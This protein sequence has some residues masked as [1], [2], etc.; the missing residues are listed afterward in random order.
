MLVCVATAI[1]SRAAQ[2]WID[3]ELVSV[4]E[5]AEIEPLAEYTRTK[6]PSALAA[7]E[8]ARLENAR[9]DGHGTS[10][11]LKVLK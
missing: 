1:R 11:S 10:R 4:G 7:L 5:P 2:L 9:P 8:T 6:D 3:G